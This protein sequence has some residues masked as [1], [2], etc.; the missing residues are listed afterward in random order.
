[1]NKKD[2][3]NKVLEK[4]RDKKKNAGGKRVKLLREKSNN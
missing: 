1:L 3:K 2:N 4:N